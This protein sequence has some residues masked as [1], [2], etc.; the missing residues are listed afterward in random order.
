MGGLISVEL[1]E[2][3]HAFPG[4]YMFKVIGR[5]ENGFVARTVA[6]VRDELA[7]PFDPPYSVRQTGGGRYVAVT[8]EVRVQSALQVLAVYKRMAQLPGLKLLL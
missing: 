6:A 4:P 8:L 1:L 3:H 2:A 7:E 5:T